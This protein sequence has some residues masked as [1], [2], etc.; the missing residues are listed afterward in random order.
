MAKEY[1]KYK[2]VEAESLCYRKKPSLKAT[3]VGYLQNGDKVTI[4]KGWSKNADGIVWYKLKSNNSHYYI[5]AKYLKRVTP[6]Y[7]DRVYKHAAEIYEEIVK[8]GCRHDFGAVNLAGLRKKK[9]VTCATAVSIV[10]QESGMLEE[11]QVINHTKSVSY[12]L[13]K[14]ITVPQ[15]ITG[16]NQVKKNT[17][18]IKRVAKN[19]SSLPAQYK[20]KGAIY[21]Y[22]SNMAIYAGNNAIY[23][24]NNG[25][26]Q[27]KDGKYIKNKML[28]GYCFTNPIIYV[29]MPND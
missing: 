3:V 11:G 1:I 6:N 9:I 28:N 15:T 14:K 24:C 12:P 25:S 21:V 8:L 23:S 22:D 29:I 19:F 4:L 26:S 18:T 13:R 17:Y 7:R 16:M 27:L 10:L 20:K 2:V 5:S